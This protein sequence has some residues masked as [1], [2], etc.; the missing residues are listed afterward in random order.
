MIKI[1]HESESIIVISDDIVS[2]NKNWFYPLSLVQDV[3]LM[4][5][6]KA[7]VTNLKSYAASTLT[8]NVYGIAT[9]QTFINQFKNYLQNPTG[10]QYWFN[11]LK[12]ID[13]TIIKDGFEKPYQKTGMWEELTAS[14]I[15]P[16]WI[17][18][19]TS[20]SIINTPAEFL[21]AISDYNS[22]LYQHINIL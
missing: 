20:G 22:K 15:P 21:A 7:F 19:M 12:D 13:A 4:S 2:R 3:N 8:S 16:S 11:G 1:K 18:T 17:D 10:F 9:K 5:L 6:P 14:G